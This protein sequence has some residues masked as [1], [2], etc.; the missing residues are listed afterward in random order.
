M[1]I[2]LHSLLMKKDISIF[3]SPWGQKQILWLTIRNRLITYKKAI[4]N[5]LFVMGGTDTTIRGGVRWWYT[6]SSSSI[7]SGFIYAATFLNSRP[8]PYRS[9]VSSLLG[10]MII[11]NLHILLIIQIGNINRCNT[12]IMIVSV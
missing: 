5:C 4:H 10:Q 11:S 12:I 1:W 2:A 3:S 9:T 6:V 7:L 8:T